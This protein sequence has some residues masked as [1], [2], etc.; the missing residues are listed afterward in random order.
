MYC[1]GEVGDMIYLTDLDLSFGG[2]V[3]AAHGIAEV[4]I[5]SSELFLPI[6]PAN[7]K[8]KGMVKQYIHR[9]L[10]LKMG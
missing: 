1:K 9:L 7:R 8:T 2:G 5:L 6:G 10:V 3:Y 4:E